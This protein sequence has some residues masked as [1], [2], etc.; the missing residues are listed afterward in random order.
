MFQQNVVVTNPHLKPAVFKPSVSEPS[1]DSAL[2]L[3]FFSSYELELQ[4]TILQLNSELADG[5]DSS[6]QSEEDE[7]LNSSLTETPSVAEC[8]T[9][10]E[11]EAVLRAQAD[12]TASLQSAVEEDVGPSNLDFT[13]YELLVQ[14]AVHDLDSFLVGAIS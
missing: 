14:K 1:V 6:S 4:E 2:S 7:P 13:N 3:E 5:D 10:R 8:T 12:L 9:S 11:E